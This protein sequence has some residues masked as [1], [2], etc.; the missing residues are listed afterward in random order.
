MKLALLA[1]WGEF[2]KGSTHCSLFVLTQAFDCDSKGGKKWLRSRPRPLS[3]PA[4]Q[5]LSLQPGGRGAEEVRKGWAPAEQ[6]G[7]HSS[8]GQSERGDVPA[9]Q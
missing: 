8:R 6:A 4:H 1:H 2:C 9:I 3:L 7:G 5:A